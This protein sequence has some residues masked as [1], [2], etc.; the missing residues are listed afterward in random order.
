MLQPLPLKRF[1]TSHYLA[2]KLQGQS[3]AHNVL[4]NMAKKF[5]QGRFDK[6]LRLPSV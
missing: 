4:S 5:F 3:A 2:I 6:L 1:A